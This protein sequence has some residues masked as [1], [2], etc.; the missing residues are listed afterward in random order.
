MVSSDITTIVSELPMFKPFNPE[1]VVTTIYA[2]LFQDV[3]PSISL[4]TFSGHLD[5]LSNIKTKGMSS[6]FSLQT[7]RPKFLQRSNLASVMR[8]ISFQ[9]Y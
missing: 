4:V 1:Q 7:G 3:T 6:Y 8:H 5:C 2:L 9:K